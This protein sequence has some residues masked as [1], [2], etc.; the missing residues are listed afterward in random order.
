M[1]RE[2]QINNYGLID[3]VSLNL[4]KGFTVIT[5]ET[6]SGKSILLGAFG[7]LLGERADSKVVRDQEKKCVVEAVF[8]I[9]DYHLQSFFESQDLDYDP[10]TT[11]RREIAPGG[12]SRAFINDTPVSLQTLK[13]LGERLVDIHSQHENSIL[14]SREFQFSVIDIFGANE[15]LLQSFK[16]KFKLYRE[17]QIDLQALRENEARMKQELDYLSFQFEE[18][19]KTELESIDQAGL[20]QELHTLQ[21]A[22][23]IKLVLA[24]ASSSML[25]EDQNVIDALTI[26]RQTLGKLSHINAE[27]S[28][29][30]DRLE[31]TLIELKELAREI[32]AY[33]EAIALDPK[34]AE[35]VQATLDQLYHLQTKHRL[36]DVSGLIAL[37]EEIATKIAQYAGVD[38]TIEA[39]E[40]EVEN[41]RAEL[42]ELSAAL[43]KARYK[44]AE[45][46]S[47]EV[48]H[49]FK[50]LHLEHAAIKLELTPAADFN[51]LGKDEI[52]FLFKANKGGQLL[53]VKQVASGGEISRVMLALKA[54]L[55]R[56]QQLPILILDEI[57]QGVSGE[58]GKKI[59]LIL[60]E[61]S[62]SMQL[63]TITHLPQIAGLATYH[64][65]VS[66]SVLG[67][68]TQTTVTKLDDQGRI[69][70]LAE[71]LN[72][73]DISEA[74]LANARELMQL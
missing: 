64:Y 52:Q 19:S 12:K 37:R 31:S 32:E 43:S 41:L 66:K 14:A 47:E 9:Q 1:I 8:D 26:I 15:K 42:E 57:D 25:T 16:S 54:A 55:S 50:A 13:A 11:I 72:G 61:M 4:E 3:H 40:K 35:H 30:N 49:Y 39:L 62:Q 44:A 20:E 56:H 33:G 17:K 2:L 69:Q 71:M 65:K 27:L 58:A 48:L 22:E 46:T 21:H 70:E 51:S 5:G 6:G 18:L 63:L 38:E 24:Q 10:Q 68:N 67:D 36:D 23:N 59:G 7:L 60:K 28:G 45:K 29:F 53:P 74:A 34:R 73:K